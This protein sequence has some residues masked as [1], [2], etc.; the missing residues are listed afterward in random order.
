MS[1]SAPP[2]GRF[3]H[4]VAQIRGFFLEGRKPSIP[5][6]LPPIPPNGLKQTLHRG[7]LGK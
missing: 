5:T 7:G 4:Q 3:S 1:I 2:G 6:N